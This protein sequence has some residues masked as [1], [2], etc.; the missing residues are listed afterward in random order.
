MGVLL[1]ALCYVMCW[2]VNVVLSVL[3]FDR[4]RGHRIKEP[5][6]SSVCPKNKCCHRD[7]LYHVKRLLSRIQPVRS[8]SLGDRC[9]Q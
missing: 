7:M 4:G 9:I 1:Y 5:C 8:L 6:I 2:N 3:A